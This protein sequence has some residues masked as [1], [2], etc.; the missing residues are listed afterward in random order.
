MARPRKE[1]SFILKRI[2]GNENVYFQPPETIKMEY[3]AIVYS[4]SNIDIRRADNKAY[5]T[6]NK[7]TLICISRK[8][9]NPVVQRLIEELPTCSYDRGYVKNNLYH[10]VLTV[11][12]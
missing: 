11:Y 4:V 10:E 9:E 12:F 2:Q 7:Y 8:K 6:H 3:D 5:S 1:L